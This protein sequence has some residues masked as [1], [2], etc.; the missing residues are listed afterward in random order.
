MLFVSA[1]KRYFLVNFFLP[2]RNS[3]LFCR[4]SCVSVQCDDVRFVSVYNMNVLKFRWLFVDIFS[5]VTCMW[6]VHVMVW[7]LGFQ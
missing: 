2:I 7:V 1:L 6:H 4:L 5:D 3:L